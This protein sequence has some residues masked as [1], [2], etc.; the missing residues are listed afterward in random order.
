[1]FPKDIQQLIIDNIDDATSLC[2]LIKNATE[3]ELIDISNCNS[4]ESL[5]SSSWFCSAPLP[6]PS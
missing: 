4:M 2:D 3:L 1:M 5:V 6:S